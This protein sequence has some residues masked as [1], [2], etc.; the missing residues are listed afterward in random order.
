MGTTCGDSC[1]SS[2]TRSTSDDPSSTV[3]RLAGSERPYLIGVRHHSPV[4]AAALPALLTA[5]APDLVLIE[6]PEELGSWLPWLA[7]SDTVAPV[8]LAVARAGREEDESGPM[9]F[10][11]FADFSPELAAIRWAAR[12]GVEVAPCDLPVAHPGWAGTQESTVDG[13][14]EPPL[15]EIAR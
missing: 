9:A 14:E 2:V 5:F 6:L 12:Y 1:G 4:L 13:T 10:Y 11:P 7:H 8:A 15:V 3:E